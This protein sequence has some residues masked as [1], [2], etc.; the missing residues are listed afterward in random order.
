[1]DKD[2]EIVDKI[3]NLR[4]SY[5]VEL[6]DSSEESLSFLDQ[7]NSL[8]RSIFNDSSLS[9]Y[10]VFS[11]EKLDEWKRKRFSR[12][13]RNKVLGNYT[14]SLYFL[15]LA[16]ITGFLVSEALDFYSID[17]VIDSKT[18]VK[19]ILTEVCFIFLSGYRAVGKWATA[20]V[21]MLRVSIFC[22]ML[23]AITSKT[24]IDSSQNTGNT[25]A[26]KEQVV[27]IQEQIE[28]KT[29]DMAY[30]L[31]KDWPRNYSATRLEKEKLTTKLINLKE[32]QA[33]GANTDVSELVTY[34][35]YGKAFFRVLLL[36]ISML[37]T[38]RIFSF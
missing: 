2:K 27:L 13:F 14:K 26:I 8:I 4:D 32:Q 25:N 15:L 5:Q 17:S 31:K 3:Q 19:A 6:A 12:W 36:F 29:K 11:Q 1:M 35:A 20:A 24:F 33:A 7:I 38:R 9:V 23:F 28:Q 30:Y 10:T 18:Y 22:L 37:I 34:K 16:T 21:G